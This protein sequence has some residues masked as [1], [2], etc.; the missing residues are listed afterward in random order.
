MPDSP[1]SPPSPKGFIKAFGHHWADYA[2]GAPSVPLTFAALFI[3]NKWAAIGTGL[4]GIACGVFAAYRVWSSERQRLLVAYERIG[5][6]EYLLT[7]TFRVYFDQERG[8]MVDAI[9]KSVSHATM[10]TY[11]TQIQHERVTRSKYFRIW[12]E[13]TT[14]A[15][16]GQCEGYIVAL[17]R[18]NSD[19][20]AF[21]HASVPQPLPLKAAPFDVVPGVR[22][23]IDFVMSD[24]TGRFDHSPEVYWPYTLDNYLSA[25]G[26]YRF[27]FR[28]HGGGVTAP[29]LRVEVHWQ[30]QWD[31][32]FAEQV[33]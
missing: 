20:E 29:P 2:S 4:L 14:D 27:T 10:S 25:P 30:G 31:A 22:K 8:G 15:P 5:G 19:E 1:N 17:E 26:T 28:V 6:L 23:A 16:V 9:A 24:E 13:A 18:R 12:I 21:I 33:A 3:S 32:I 7:P 11:G